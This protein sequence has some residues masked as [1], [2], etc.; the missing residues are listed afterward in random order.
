MA[1]I[2]WV[3]KLLRDWAAWKT[4]G[5]GS[6]YPRTNVL[7]PTWSPPSPGSTPTLKAYSANLSPVVDAAIRK[8]SERH[9][10]TVWVCYCTQR[11]LAERAEYLRCQPAT[12]DARVWTIHRE[13]QRLLG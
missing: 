10:R 2:E 12:V 9:Q 3:E 1:R 13:L 4:V 6:G 7:D 5:D 11:T 8:L